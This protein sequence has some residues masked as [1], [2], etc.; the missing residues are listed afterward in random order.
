MPFNPSSDANKRKHCTICESLD[1]HTRQHY[2]LSPK[3]H[4]RSIND[5][6]KPHKSNNPS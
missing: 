3:I 5:S 1:H 4:I 2:D 6:N